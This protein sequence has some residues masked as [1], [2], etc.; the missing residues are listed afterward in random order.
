MTL[1]D[2]KVVVDVSKHTL[3]PKAGSSDELRRLIARLIEE[4]E[5]GYVTCGQPP[6]QVSR[7]ELEEFELLI[8][9]PVFSYRET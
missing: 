8:G 6:R 1:D 5:Q 7:A 4:A 3:T 2:E 9:L